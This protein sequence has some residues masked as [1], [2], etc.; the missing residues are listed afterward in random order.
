MAQSHL[1][2]PSAGRPLKRDLNIGSTHF[3]CHEYASSPLP[4]LPFIPPVC[5]FL[6]SSW[7]L[8]GGFFKHSKQVI[9]NAQ[10]FPSYVDKVKVGDLHPVQQPG[11]Y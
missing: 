4:P 6:Y 9:P 5:L 3:S 8:V 7:R 2:L 11:S 10:H 1:S